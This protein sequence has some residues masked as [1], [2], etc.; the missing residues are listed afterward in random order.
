MGVTGVLML[1]P[2]SVSLHEQSSLDSVESFNGLHSWGSQSS[3]ADT[4]RVPSIDSFDED[5]SAPQFC[6]G[7]QNLSFKD[8]IQEQN[9]PV[10]LGKPVVPAAVLARFTGEFPV[11]TLKMCFG[12]LMPSSCCY[13]L[14]YCT[15]LYILREMLSI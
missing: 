9:V 12:F 8:Y 15:S 10:G 2:L 6:V 4:Q 13:S 7:K 11:I 1:Y 14:L 5:C 3:L